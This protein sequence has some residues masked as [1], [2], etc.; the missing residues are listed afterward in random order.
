M[1]KPIMEKFYA[2]VVQG[3]NLK[4]AL[5]LKAMLDDLILYRVQRIIDRFKNDLAPFHRISNWKD[6]DAYFTDCF[7]REAHLGIDVIVE[8][9]SYVFQFWDRNDDNG[10]GV[11][12]EEI[13]QRMG[14]L[15]HYVRD[16]GKFSKTFAF[17]SEE[18]ELINH[19]VDFKRQLS[20]IV[21]EVSPEDR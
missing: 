10:Q 13:L 11:H 15:A 7:W 8:P 6:A 21:N 5:A 3:E 2:L 16:D 12:A 20:T 1:N 17:P 4:T 14:N 9:E 18:E 19:I